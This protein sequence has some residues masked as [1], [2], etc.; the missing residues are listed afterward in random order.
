MEIKSD[1]YNTKGGKRLIEYIENKY[2]ECYFQAKNT[3]ETDVNRLKALE[4]MA[5]LDTIINI[6]GEENK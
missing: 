2:N 3:K 6:L 5:F 4:L 1:I